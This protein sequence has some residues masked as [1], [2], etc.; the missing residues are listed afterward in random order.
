[1]AP[2]RMLMPKKARRIKKQTIFYSGRDAGSPGE[3]TWA[4]L[5]RHR[6]HHRRPNTQCLAPTPW[7]RQKDPNRECLLEE[8]QTQT[9]HPAAST[10]LR[11]TRVAIKATKA[12]GGDE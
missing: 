3:S 6:L 2:K 10:G 5:K 7:W 4:A 12:H 8:Q 9:R 11:T 1:M